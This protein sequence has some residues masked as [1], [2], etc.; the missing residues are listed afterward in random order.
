VDN[1]AVVCNIMPYTK[2]TDSVLDKAPPL[3][4]LFS[5]KAEYI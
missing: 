4:Y 1:I 2:C 3:F 5:S